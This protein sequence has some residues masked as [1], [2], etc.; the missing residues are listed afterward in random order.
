MRPFSR[1]TRWLLIALAGAAAMLAGALPVL[2]SSG[3]PPAPGVTVQAGSVDTITPDPAAGPG[4]QAVPDTTAPPSSTSSVPAASPSHPATTV[5][6]APGAPRACRAQNLEMTAGTDRVTYRPG[7]HIV[8]T[9]TVI[10]QSAQPCWVTDRGSA[11]SA[12]SCDPQVLLQLYD[13]TDGYNALLG[14]YHAACGPDP[15][16]LAPGDSA[17]GQVDF[18]FAP[19][20]D[21]GPDPAAPACRLRSGS[22]TVVVNWLTGGS[23]AGDAGMSAELA[24]FC[25]PD[26]CSAAPSAQNGPSTTTT[27]AGPS[28][29]T[30]STTAPTAASTTAPPPHKSPTTTSTSA[31][32]SKSTSTTSRPAS[33]RGGG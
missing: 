33:G 28:T 23:G 4:D 2:V 26:A 27:T 13:A 20:R 6:T 9:A 18:T 8:V 24:F 21:C 12:P 10:N 32:A 31:P 16:V 14:P 5:T 30:T 15:T 25:P 22:W 29:S 11:S 17:T 3:R 19:P 7:D 1:R